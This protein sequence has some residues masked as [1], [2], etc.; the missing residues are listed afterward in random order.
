VGSL[1]KLAEGGFN[2]VLPAT[3]D[4]GYAVTARLLYST[5]VPECHAVASE[6]TTLDLLLSHGVPAPKVLAYPL[7]RTNPV[8][9]DYTLLEK[10]EGT[11]LSNQWFSMDNKPES[12]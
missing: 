4:D 5:T 6:A 7:D 2:R 3:F 11:P 1:A 12:K 10:I 8:G 9:A